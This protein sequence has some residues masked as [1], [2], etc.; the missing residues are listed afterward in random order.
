MSKTKLLTILL[1]AMVILN[2]VMIGALIRPKPGHSADPQKMIIEKLDLDQKQIEL[3]QVLIT[4]HQAG[5][6]LK[7]DEMKAAKNALFM[8]L[9][10]ADDSEKTRL[11]DEIASIQKEIEN[12]HYMHFRDLGNICR[13]DQ[14]ERFN[15]LTH[16]L[17]GVFARPLPPPK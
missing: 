10:D 4:A 3:Y 6:R 12:I 1:A 11:I 2:V 5:V 13:P 15:A 14:Q 9:T 8:S 7:M 17:A 16:E